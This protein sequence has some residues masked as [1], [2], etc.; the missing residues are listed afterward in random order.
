MLI[1][2]LQELCTLLKIGKPEEIARNVE[3]QLVKKSKEYNVL[4]D[5]KFVFLDK[6]EGK[7]AFAF[8]SL[9]FGVCQFFFTSILAQLRTTPCKEAK[10][11]AMAGDFGLGA[12]KIYC[13]LIFA[14]VLKWCHSCV[15]FWFSSH[16]NFCRC[17]GRIKAGKSFLDANIALATGKLRFLLC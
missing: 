9:H 13:H 1:F 2:E 4:L 8:F 12:E 5:E 10:E 3:D 16:F 15:H 6:F 7:R 17:Q 14:S 11:L